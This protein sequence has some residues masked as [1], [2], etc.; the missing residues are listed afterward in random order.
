GSQ[1]AYWT[2]PDDPLPLRNGTGRIFVVD[3]ATS[4]THQ[5]RPDFAAAVDPVWSPDGKSILFLGLKDAA[6][7]LHT[8]DWWVT[9]VAGGTAVQCHVFLTMTG[10]DLNPFAWRANRVYLNGDAPN[11]GGKRAGVVTIDPR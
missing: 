3:V 2:G 10:G 8:S 4:T 1:I 5:L 11:W 6:D 7:V 9:P